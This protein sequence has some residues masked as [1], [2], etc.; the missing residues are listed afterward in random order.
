M[1]QHKTKGE[2]LHEEL[3]TCLASNPKGQ[4]YAQCSRICNEAQYWVLDSNRSD[5]F[6][7]TRPKGGKPFGVKSVNSGGSPQPSW[8]V[9]VDEGL[10]TNQKSG[11]MPRCDN[12]VFNDAVFY[13][14]EA[15]MQVGG[16]NWKKEFDD[17]VENKIPKTKAL[18]DTALGENG[19]AITQEIRIAIPYPGSNN[20]VPR[21]NLQK[22]EVLRKEARRHCKWVSKV[23]LEDTI[24]L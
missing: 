21:N 5:C 14:V 4:P 19:S 13:F 18:I 17:A 16:D 9:C 23:T 12:L 15:K 11:S 2:Q 24:L 7:P 20:R 3:I 22:E 8:L 1:K 6:S 10:I